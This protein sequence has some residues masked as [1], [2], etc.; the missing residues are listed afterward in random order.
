MVDA[1]IASTHIVYTPAAPAQGR[2]DRLSAH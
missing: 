1:E 2:R